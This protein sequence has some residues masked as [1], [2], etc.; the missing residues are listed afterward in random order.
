MF[1]FC[2]SHSEL[3]LE[4]GEGHAA[5][6]H[7]HLR[8]DAAAAPGGKHRRGIGVSKLVWDDACGDAERV[9]DLMQVVSELADESEFSCWTCQQ[10]PIWRQRIEGAEEAEALD[11][12]C[13]EGIAGDHAFGLEFTEGDM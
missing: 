8:C 4:I 6:A 1:G 11:E 13:D 10:P 2:A 9:A 12:F 5:I 7:G 3:A